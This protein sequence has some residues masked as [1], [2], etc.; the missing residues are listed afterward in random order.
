MA[1]VLEPLPGRRDVVGGALARPPSSAPGGRCSHARP[2]LRT[3]RA[4]RAGRSRAHHHFDG[5]P[6]GGRRDEARLARVEARARELVGRRRVEAD[7]APSSVGIGSCTKSTSRR[8]VSAKPTTVSGDAMK[9][10]VDALPSLR[11]GKF[12]LNDDTIVLTLAGLDVVALPLPDAR[13]A[14]VREHR[15]A[16]GLE[17]LEVAVALDRRA[18]LLG[19]RGDHAAEC[20]RAAPLRSPGAP[21]ARRGRCP[22]TTSSCTN[23]RARP[24][25][26]AGSP[27][28]PQ[29]ARA[30]RPSDRGRE[31]AGRPRAARA[32]RGRCR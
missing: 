24:R 21:R 23:P 26:R 17:V 30:P 32:R 7:L 6:V 3:A 15:R 10:S 18:H 27:P 19:A 8:P 4:A 22:R 9:L 14:R 28:P 29:R 16:D 31:C 1:A 25:C 13:A 2:T 12:R 11:A 20:A 5:R